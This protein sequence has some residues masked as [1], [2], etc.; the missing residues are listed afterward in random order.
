MNEN[1]RDRRTHFRRWRNKNSKL[2]R[3]WGNSLA[4][5]KTK[6]LGRNRVIFAENRVLGVR[7]GRIRGAG[8]PATVPLC[9]TFFGELWRGWLASPGRTALQTHCHAS[10]CL[11]VVFVG[12]HWISS[13]LMRVLTREIVNRAGRVVLFSARGEIGRLCPIALN[14]TL[15]VNVNDD[16]IIAWDA[17]AS[18]FFGDEVVRTF[19]KDT[20]ES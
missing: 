1:A 10:Y 14:P 20:V 7:A 5:S 19:E 6:S 9:G 18:P 11:A 8:L 12:G 2:G 16:S 17:P 3:R 15:S 13:R 4:R